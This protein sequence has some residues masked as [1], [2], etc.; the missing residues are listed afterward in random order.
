MCDED[1]S[2]S[3]NGSSKTNTAGPTGH[4]YILSI[5]INKSAVGRG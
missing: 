1:N 2:N 3:D 5:E 4:S